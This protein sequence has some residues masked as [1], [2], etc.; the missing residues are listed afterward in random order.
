[1]LG[2]GIAALWCGWLRGGNWSI[3]LSTALI[4]TAIVQGKILANNAEWS[5]RLTLPIGAVCVLAAGALLAA[6]CFPH[7]G[8]R[9][10]PVFAAVALAALLT[11]PTVW[12]VVSV[13]AGNGGA[14]LPEADPSST[15]G[16]GGTNGQGRGFAPPRARPPAP[17]ASNRAAPAPRP[18]TA[19][20][21]A[22]AFGGV[23]QLQL[24]DCAK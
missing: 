22:A 5:A 20:R 13:Q 24:Y 1:M 8:R 14:W 9:A 18:G 21:R 12:S 6:R 7:L 10:A 4:G 19:A 3:G 17:T 15:G 11:A 23:G 2:P 16:F